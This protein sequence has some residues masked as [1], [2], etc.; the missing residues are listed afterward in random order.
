MYTLQDIAIV[1]LG[2][3]GWEIAYSRPFGG[4]FLEDIV[5][6][7]LGENTSYEP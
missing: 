4:V 2:P 1:T 6:P 5:G 7:C 3:V